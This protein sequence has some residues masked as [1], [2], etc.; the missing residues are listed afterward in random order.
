[1]HCIRSFTDLKEQR[2]LVRKILRD[3]GSGGHKARSHPAKPFVYAN[4]GRWI[5]GQPGTELL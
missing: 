5:P 2:Q 3:L 4:N 1:M